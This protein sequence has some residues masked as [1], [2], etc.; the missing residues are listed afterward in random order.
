LAKR[1]F[2]ALSSGID[3]ILEASEN[4]A[5]FG[6]GDWFDKVK[7]D[8]VYKGKDYDIGNKIFTDKSAADV[9]DMLLAAPEDENARHTFYALKKFDGYDENG[10]E[11]YL[12]K[13]GIAGEGYYNRYLGQYIEDGFI[14]IFE[15]RVANAKEIENI[16]HGTRDALDARALDKGQ[17]FKDGKWLN[18][19]KASTVNWG[20]GYTELYNRDILGL[21]GLM[22]P[23]DVETKSKAMYEA[24]KKRPKNSGVVDA[25]QAG[26]VG[27]G[28]NIADFV[29]NKI[30]RL[31]SQTLKKLSSQEWIDNFVGYD[32]VDSQRDL[33]EAYYDFK[34][35]DYGSAAIN[36]LSAAPETLAESAPDIALFMIDAPVGLAVK[37][38]GNAGKIN[39]AVKLGELGVKEAKLAKDALFKDAIKGGLSPRQAKKILD[40]PED[41]NFVTTVLKTI[42]GLEFLI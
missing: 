25:F 29:G 23:S 28:T 33:T 40:A 32:R 18:T 12:Y 8:A 21:D 26:A 16:L 6:Q 5:D 42:Q 27:L 34:R 1:G 39:R 2:N 37:L 14:P 22:N 24:Y 41:V 20:S 10:K 36:A 3:W 7:I 4:V 38:A 17:V 31:N 13:Y 35:G 19:D 30:F 9:R 11:K 15:R